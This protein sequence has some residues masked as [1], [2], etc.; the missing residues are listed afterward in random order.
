MSRFS[1]HVQIWRY[2]G[3]SQ[4]FLQAWLG[5]VFEYTYVAVGLDTHLTLITA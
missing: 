3:F 1:M 5:V 2:R 4:L